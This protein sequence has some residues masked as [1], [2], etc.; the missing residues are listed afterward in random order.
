MKI[1]FLK[2]NGFDISFASKLKRFFNYFPGLEYYGT[3]LFVIAKL[4]Q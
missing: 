4:K 2:K 3:E 1:N